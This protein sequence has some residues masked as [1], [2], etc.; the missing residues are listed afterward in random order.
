MWNLFFI[1][2]K[3]DRFLLIGFV[4]TKL[5]L[6]ISYM[7]NLFFIGNKDYFFF[8]DAGFVTALVSAFGFSAAASFVLLFSPA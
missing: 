8:L 2:H 3:W 5:L 6:A 4:K 1:G 7:W